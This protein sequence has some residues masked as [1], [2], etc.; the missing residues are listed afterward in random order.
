MSVTLNRIRRWLGLSLEPTQPMTDATMPDSEAASS[1]WRLHA[2]L[3]LVYGKNWSKSH[4]DKVAMFMQAL[5]T[6]ELAA[7]MA[8]LRQIIA[9]GSGAF[10]VGIE[11]TA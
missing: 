10:T 4:P 9:D 5:A 2:A 8:A 7:E 3:D 6:K 1:I 11:K